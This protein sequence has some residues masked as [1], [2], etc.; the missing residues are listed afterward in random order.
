MSAENPH[1]DV[2]KQVT[3]LLSESILENESDLAERFHRF[4][5]ELLV[6]VRQISKDAL[7]KVGDS[8]VE[9]E[10]AKVKADGLTAQSRKSSPFLPSSEKSE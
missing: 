2:M 4:D 5:E 8:V 1:A 9:K 6:L 3:D 7:Q 10:E